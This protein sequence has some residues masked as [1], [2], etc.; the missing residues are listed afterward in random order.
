MND[1]QKIEELLH[2]YR[3]DQKDFAKMCGFRPQVLSDIKFGKCGISKN[4][5]PKILKAFPEVNKQWLIDD[6]E[7][8]LVQNKIATQNSFSMS[9]FKLRGYAPYYSD[10]QV[11]AGQY[12]L[13]TI[14]QSEEPQSWIKFPNITVDAWFPI[15]GCSMEPKIL[16]GDTI[17][18]IQMNNWDKI[19]PDKIYFIIT[20][21]DRMI[22]KL[23]VDHE[24]TTVLWGVSTNHPKIKI[25]TDEIKGI[26]H[27]VWAGR[28][29]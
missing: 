16:A 18:V 2:H 9:E 1:S 20:I 26:Y 15:V 6:D 12:D 8:M 5:A 11:S 21:Y 29:V 13:A 25:S 24:N 7:N 10:L 3:M 14:E 17:G 4:V 22:K 27:V 28:L 19:D 23:E